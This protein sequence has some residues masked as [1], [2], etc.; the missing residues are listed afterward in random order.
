KDKI[1]YYTVKWKSVATHITDPK[2]K[3]DQPIVYDWDKLEFK[4][5]AKGGS[6]TILRMPT[7]SLVELEMHTTQ[8]NEGENSHAPHVHH[9]EEMMLVRYGKV[10]EMIIDKSYELGPGSVIYL[11]PDDLHGIGN[12]GKEP[13]EYYAIRWITEKTEVDKK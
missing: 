9:D 3:T 7:Q 10:A 12:A 4:K 5:N 11:A 2:V 6:R 13:C 1:C 8:L